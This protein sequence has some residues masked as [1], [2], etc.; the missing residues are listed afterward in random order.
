MNKLCV[1]DLYKV[2]EIQIIYRNKIPANDRPKV[3]SSKEAFNLFI[4]SWD[5]NRIELVEQFKIMLLNRG[6]RVMGIS[7]ISTGGICG[8]NAD[9]KIAF[10]TAVKAGACGI[11]LAHNHPSGNLEPSLPDKNL[12]AKFKSAGRFLD[13]EVLDHFIVGPRSYYSFMDEGLMP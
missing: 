9:P 5:M 11:I 8:C 1:P 13:I 3:T 10:G 4:S 7:E 6:N 2:S 12:T